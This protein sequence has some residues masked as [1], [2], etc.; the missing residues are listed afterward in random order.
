MP[1]TNCSNNDHLRTVTNCYAAAYPGH[2]TVNGIAVA[3]SCTI[4]ND[5]KTLLCPSS[6][7]V[8]KLTGNTRRYIVLRDRCSF[9]RF[10]FLGISFFFR[11]IDNPTC[12][13]TT[14]YTII[15]RYSTTYILRLGNVASVIEPEWWSVN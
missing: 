7:R 4:Y 2:G 14:I 11:R 8:K 3:T 12:S 1:R 15:T 9:F 5:E 10:L 6:E 13:C